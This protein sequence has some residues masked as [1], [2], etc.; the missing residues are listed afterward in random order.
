MDHKSGGKV[1]VLGTFGDFR[2]ILLNVHYGQVA[3]TN[4]RA[5][6]GAGAGV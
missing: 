3:F 6:A 2:D 1:S 5:D 4:Y